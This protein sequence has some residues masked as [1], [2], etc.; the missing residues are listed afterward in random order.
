M[1]GAVQRGA[2]PSMGD[3]GSTGDAFP[4]RR[5]GHTWI[6]TA[7]RAHGGAQPLERVEPEERWGV[8]RGSRGVPGG[9]SGGEDGEPVQHAL[10]TNG[11]GS[12]STPVTRS[13]RSRTDS[14]RSTGGGGTVKS[15][16][17]CARAVA[18]R[19]LARS[20]KCRM[21]PSMISPSSARS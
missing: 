16:R 10:L 9:G 19:R 15:R 3:G 13:R 12:M 4:R 18:R 17:H 14:A 5:A 20:P 7:A 11:T 6:A 2:S 8:R 21:R 1:K